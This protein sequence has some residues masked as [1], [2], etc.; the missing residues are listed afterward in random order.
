MPRASKKKIFGFMVVLSSTLLGSF[1]FC[2]FGEETNKVFKKDHRFGATVE[3]ASCSL[4]VLRD[5][6]TGGFNLY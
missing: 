2:F 1:C 6:L 4:A 5:P 3:F